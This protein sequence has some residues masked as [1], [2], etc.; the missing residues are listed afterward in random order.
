MH[1]RP[2]DGRCIAYIYKA[3]WGFICIVEQ[4]VLCIVEWGVLCIVEWGVLCRV[5]WGVI[6][7]V[8]WDVIYIVEQGVICIAQKMGPTYV[9]LLIFPTFK[10]TEKKTTHHK[11]VH[12]MASI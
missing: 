9:H 1:D 11:H 5:E 10:Y 4:G 3:Q 8:E 12:S 6:C 7:R 2:I